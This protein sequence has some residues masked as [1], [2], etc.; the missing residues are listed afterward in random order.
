MEDSVEAG[1]VQILQKGKEVLKFRRFNFEKGSSVYFKIPVT[2]WPCTVI[3]KVCYSDVPEECEGVFVRGYLL[4]QL[5]LDM[6]KMSRGMRDKDISN[7]SF[8]LPWIRDW[9]EKRRIR[10]RLNK[11]KAGRQ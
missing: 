9:D 11:L 7:L 8:I 2:D 4:A 6:A 5:T 1:T 10:G 3:E